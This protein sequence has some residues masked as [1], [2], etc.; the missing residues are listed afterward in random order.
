MTTSR[1]TWHEAQHIRLAEGEQLLAFLPVTT[2]RL[3]R[4]ELSGLARIVDGLLPETMTGGSGIT[5]PV[6]TAVDQLVAEIVVLTDALR[7]AR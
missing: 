5:R 1:P 4:G 2:Q 6:E 7:G 3:L